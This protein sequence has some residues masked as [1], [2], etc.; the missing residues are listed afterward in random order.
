MH[1]LRCLKHL[2]GLFLIVLEMTRSLNSDW[3]FVW[4]YK[5][6]TAVLGPYSINAWQIQFPWLNTI[7]LPTQKYSPVW[8]TF[9]LVIWA[10]R[11][12]DN[13]A[14][15]ENTALWGGR[16]QIDSGECISCCFISGG[17]LFNSII[18]GKTKLLSFPVM[19][20]I[21][22]Q[23]FFYHDDILKRHV[24]I[25]REDPLKIKTVTVTYELKDVTRLSL[26]T[27]FKD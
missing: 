7:F 22:S 17:I 26:I 25:S 18:I 9:M 4:T 24:S 15:M 13:L 21:H 19:V 5:Q 12:S 3:S 1:T 27:V 10:C 2:A 8:S 23:G 11:L 6:L 14:R 20:P 16:G